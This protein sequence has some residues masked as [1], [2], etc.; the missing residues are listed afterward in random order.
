MRSSTSEPTT[1]YL[2]AFPFQHTLTY[3][4]A[5][6]ETT[7]LR[8][9]ASHRRRSTMCQ[10]RSSFGFHP[11]LTLPGSDRRRLGLELPVAER[12]VLD[13]QMLP[14][15]GGE[16]AG[17]GRLDGPLGE[18]E[19]DDN[20]PS[21]AA[22]HSAPTFASPTPDAGSSSNFDDRLSSRAGVRADAI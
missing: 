9:C 10:C 8:I 16:T 5:I 11:Y 12:A 14:T 3:A 18:R 7:H 22:I 2:M 15:G 13:A 4:A 21:C 6:D 17:P 20:F 19:F 1:E